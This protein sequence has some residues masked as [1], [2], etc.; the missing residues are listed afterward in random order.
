M[1][2]ERSARGWGESYST[3]DP[4]WWAPGPGQCQ[5]SLE[6]PS[7]SAPVSTPVFLPSV[8]VIS[9]FHPWLLAAPDC[10]RLDSFPGPSGQTGPA[11]I[12][13]RKGAG[14]GR[15]GAGSQGGA[16]WK[17]E[18]PVRGPARDGVQH[19]PVCAP[20]ADGAARCPPCLL[21]LPVGRP[22][23]RCRPLPLGALPSRCL[24]HAGAWSNPMLK[25]RRENPSSPRLEEGFSFSVTKPHACLS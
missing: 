11:L 3:S 20:R 6:A 25:C 19:R 14:R 7:P 9:R 23:L 17:S 8:R 13:L 18:V 2:L 21:R 1:A 16:E 5:R 24:L 15:G 12:G 10:L 22:G 4:H